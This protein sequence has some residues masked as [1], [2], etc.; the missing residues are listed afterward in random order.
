MDKVSV[1]I[2]TYNRYHPLLRTIESVKKQT[3]KNIE[4]IVVNDCSTEK[5]YYEHN[6]SD[7]KMIHL[8]KNSKS[9]F[10]FSC[11]GGYQ[12][13]FGMKKATG[14]YFAF[15]DDDDIWLPNKLE[16]QIKQMRENNSKMSCTDGYTG[17]GIYNPSLTYPT[18]EGKFGQIIMNILYKKG[19]IISLEDIYPRFISKKLIQLHNTI[20]CSSVVISSDITEKA[21]YFA[22]LNFADDREY[23]VRILD[24]TDCLYVSEPLMYYDEGHANGILY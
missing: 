8:E 7:I 18:R 23:W 5:E 12:R 13:N 2:P 14:K 22:N 9:V 1:I 3:Y 6:W 17:K 21:G 20:I 16:V 4:I 11:P 19:S 10:G 24:H 15:C